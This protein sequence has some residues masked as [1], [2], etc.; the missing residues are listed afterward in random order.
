MRKYLC[1]RDFRVD[2]C[3]EEGF[4]TGKTMYVKAGTIYERREDNA[5]I[6][7]GRIA[8]ESSDNW[9]EICEKTLT[10]MFME[11]TDNLCIYECFCKD[12]EA[13]IRLPRP[14]DFC[15]KCGS[16]DV[17]DSLF[18]TCD[19]G[20]TV[21]F[22]AECVISYCYNCGKKHLTPLKSC[23]ICGNKTEIHGGPEEWKPTMTDPDSGG[24]PYYIKCKCGIHF[25]TGT[26]EYE[27]LLKAWN[28][29]IDERETL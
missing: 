13:T 27:E 5:R 14:L 18:T 8:L 2:D 24:T 3:D 21:Y 26:H 17:Y 23:P 22:D 11:I 15:Y 28:T 20:T 7:G 4:V 6:I 16:K 1:V 10:D 29:R 19:C 25:E 9:L 12:C